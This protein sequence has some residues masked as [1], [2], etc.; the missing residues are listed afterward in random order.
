MLAL[1]SNPV[2]TATVEV[3]TKK[4]QNRVKSPRHSHPATRLQSAA[5]I[6]ELSLQQKR[7]L[8]DRSQFRTELTLVSQSSL[9]YRKSLEQADSLMNQWFDE[10]EAIL[11]LVAERSELHPHSDINILILLNESGKRHQR[12]IE[13]FLTLLWDCN[14]K[15]GSSVRTIAECAFEGAADLTIITTMIESRLLSGAP[16]LFA[17]MNAAIRPEH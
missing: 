17:K 14:L 16:E 9:A 1:L 15:V 6:I 7:Q 2:T 13:Q 3:K 5:M 10:N 12:A 4:L 11:M 8:F